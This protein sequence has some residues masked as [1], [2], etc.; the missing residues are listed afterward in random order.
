MRRMRD[1]IKLPVKKPDLEE[2]L[3]FVKDILFDEENNR[4]TGFIIEKDFMLKSQQVTVARENIRSV[5][6][7]FL[8]VLDLIPRDIQGTSWSR[9]VGTKVFDGDGELKGRVADVFVD[10]LA[11]IVVGYEI[12]DGL[13]ADLVNGRDMILEKNIL[14]ESQD[15]IVIEGGSL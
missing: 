2:Q 14:A 5:G 12:T 10:N 7:D 3:G 4:L 13:L 1:L 6:K 11:E 9:K 15:V 8:L